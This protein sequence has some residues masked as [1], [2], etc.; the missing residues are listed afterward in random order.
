MATNQIIDAAKKVGPT[1][2]GAGVG[3]LVAGPPGALIGAAVGLVTGLIHKKVTQ[4]PNVAGETEDYHAKVFA[5]ALQTLRDPEKLE[6]LAN[7]F[8]RA[9]KPHH[10]MI[11]R[12]RA[13]LTR[14]SPE[15]KKARRETFKALLRSNDIKALDQAALE[16]D[17][18]GATGQAELVRRYADALR[19]GAE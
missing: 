18:E 2:A 1:A 16:Y 6:A 7:A 9:D 10:A 4:T 19:R 12:K 17:A 5:S 11:L 8:D 15:Q 14:L 13:M 3:F